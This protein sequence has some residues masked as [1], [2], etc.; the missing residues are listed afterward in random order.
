MVIHIKDVYWKRNDKYILKN[1]NWAV[2]PGEHWAI[3]GLNGS[4]K[5]A[6]LNI[7]NGYMWPTKGMVSVLD[8]QFGKFDL[9]ELRKSIGW[10]SSSLQEKLYANET[11]Q[12][13]VMSGKFASIGLHDQVT[14][15]DKE[16]ALYLLEELGCQDF[17][18]R[19]YK[20]LSQGEKQKVLIARALISR[21]EL[22]ILDEACN[23]LDIFA[24]EQLLA[25]VSNLCSHEGGPTIL[26]VTHHIEE[27][28]PAFTKTLLIRKGEV[29]AA[30]GTKEVLTSETLSEFFE[31]PVKVE[32]QKD[33]AWLSLI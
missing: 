28:L 19:P 5:T 31:V 22:L 27:I 1:I 29:F 12:E 33:R 20:T 18:Q 23:G 14:E 32:W 6:L 15:E 30:E 11:A 16:V 9:R 7:I 10:V 25:L 13:I 8:K 21:P 3:L 17:A 24:R 2:K 26:Y 4:G